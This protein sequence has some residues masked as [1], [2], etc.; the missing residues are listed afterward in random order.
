MIDC[1]TRCRWF[2]KSFSLLMTAN[3]KAAVNFEHS[4]GDGVAVLRYFNDVFKDTTK[5]AHVHPDTKPAKV[6]SKAAVKRLGELVLF[7]SILFLYDELCLY[8]F[9]LRMLLLSRSI[10]LYSRWI[11]LVL[12]LTGL[13]FSS[14]LN[15]IPYVC[16]T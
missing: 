5:N 4:W 14:L 16:V 1:F 10:L 3:G 9:R 6:D 7:C 2:D 11:I 12:V 13:Y 15:Y 8:N